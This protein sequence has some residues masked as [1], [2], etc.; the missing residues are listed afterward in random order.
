MR[1][2]ILEKVEGICFSS[3]GLNKLLSAPQWL[4]LGWAGNCL[5]TV[6]AST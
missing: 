6:F 1:L 2:K 3:E 5:V 4:A